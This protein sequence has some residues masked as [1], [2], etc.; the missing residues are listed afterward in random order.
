[1][2]IERSIRSEIHEIQTRESTPSI[3]IFRFP[4]KIAAER[5]R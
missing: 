4:R 3:G 1:M 5:I 2:M